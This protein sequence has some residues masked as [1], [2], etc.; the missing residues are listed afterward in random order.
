PAFKRLLYGAAILAAVGGPP[1]AKSARRLGSRLA[2][3]E[4]C[5]RAGLEKGARHEVA[6]LTFAEEYL[7]SVT[8]NDAE[9]VLWLIGTHHGNGRP[10]FPAVDWPRMDGERI[11]PAFDDRKMF[12]TCTRSLAALT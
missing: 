2:Y 3:A 7:K 9:L 1:L 12:G 11:E 6:S 4:A 8:A 10:F 5:R